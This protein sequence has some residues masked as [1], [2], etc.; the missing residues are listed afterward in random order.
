MKEIQEGERASRE[1]TTGPGHS[2]DE[3]KEFGLR[4]TEVLRKQFT[5]N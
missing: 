2:S 5:L 3:I 1:D 4:R